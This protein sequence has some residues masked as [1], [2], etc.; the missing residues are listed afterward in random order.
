MTCI[1]CPYVD[2]AYSPTHSLPAAQQLMSAKPFGRKLKAEGFWAAFTNSQYTGMPQ[3]ICALLNEQTE[4]QNALAH[5]RLCGA[6]HQGSPPTVQPSNMWHPPPSLPPALLPPCSPSFWDTLPS[7]EQAAASDGS[8][9]TTLH[10]PPHSHQTPPAHT[11]T[12]THAVQKKHDNPASL[13]QPNK[14]SPLPVCNTL[15]SRTWPALLSCIFSLSQPVLT[16]LCT[17]DS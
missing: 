14:N 17:Q 11:Y 2:T 1:R 10:L 3:E 6:L 16:I 13:G 15:R 12:C 7:A 5:E 8:P 4:C 9:G